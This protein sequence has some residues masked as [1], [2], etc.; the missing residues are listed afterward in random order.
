MENNSNS[1]KFHFT[2]S[3]FAPD[4]ATKGLFLFLIFQTL[5]TLVYQALYLVGLQAN[6]W[7]L[8]FT[9]I[10]DFCFVACVFSVSKEKKINVF[11]NIK[12]KKAPNFKEIA[13]CIAISVICLFGFSSLTNLFL[14]VL[15][16]AG[17]SSVTSDIVI[18]NF[19]TYLLYV[20]LI[21]IV[22]AL[23]EEILFRGLICNGLKK[24]GTFAAVFGSAFLFM[25][26]HGSPDQTVH[27]INQ[28]Q[29][30][31]QDKLVHRLIWATMH[32]HK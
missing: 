9:L 23:C 25:I 29:N 32:D 14:E 19:G 18:P 7:S 5:V 12:V 15:Y 26:M 22:P 1:I 17:Y 6:I 10:L 30:N 28:R 11:S 31:P 21:C 8:I 27:Q 20:G 4:D 3:R 24:L 13:I 16:K 2:N